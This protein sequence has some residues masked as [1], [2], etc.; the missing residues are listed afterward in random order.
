MGK[1]IAINTVVNN[2]EVSTENLNEKSYE[3]QFEM[4]T[5]FIDHLIQTDFNRLLSILYRVDIS[6]EKLKSKL[7]ESKDQQFSSRIIAQMLIDREV[8]KIASRAKY[9]FKE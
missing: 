3:T 2:L 1:E 4:L 8:E 7:A 5:Q 6:E 9:R